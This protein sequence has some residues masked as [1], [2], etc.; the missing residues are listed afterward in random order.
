LYMS[1]PTH[2]TRPRHT[3][4]LPIYIINNILKIS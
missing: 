3:R 4:Y 1:N 2:L